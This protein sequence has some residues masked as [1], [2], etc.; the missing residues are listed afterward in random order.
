MASR[1]AEDP[2]GDNLGV[3]WDLRGALEAGLGSGMRARQPT[4]AFTCRQPR[5]RP[6]SSSSCGP[7]SYL[8][9]YCM[10]KALQL[11]QRSKA[12]AAGERVPPCQILSWFAM[13]QHGGINRSPQHVMIAPPS[14]ECCTCNQFGAPTNSRQIGAAMSAYLGGRHESSGNPEESKRCWKRASPTPAVMACNEQ[15]MSLVAIACYESMYSV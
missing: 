1:L 9:A 13:K 8:A 15:V 4:A 14:A 10:C 6:L 12:N 3:L 7:A 2:W 11:Q 5:P